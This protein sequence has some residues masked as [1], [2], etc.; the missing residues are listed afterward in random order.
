[1]T[2]EPKQNVKR[3]RHGIFEELFA[4]EGPSV[5]S[6][7]DECLALADEAR[8]ALDKKPM[9]VPLKTVTN[10]DH[11]SKSTIGLM[12]RPASEDGEKLTGLRSQQQLPVAESDRA[13]LAAT[14]SH[15]QRLLLSF[16]AVFPPTQPRDA[17]LTRDRA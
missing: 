10:V 11:E 16:R 7:V 13:R 4:E 8:K 3:L 6:A 15:P 17:P 2:A 9:D 12:V 5:M 1:M 14:H